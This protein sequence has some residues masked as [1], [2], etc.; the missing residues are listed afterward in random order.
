[1][2]QNKKNA[3]ASWGT[4]PLTSFYQSNRQEQDS[5]AD[6]EQLPHKDDIQ[7]DHDDDV[8]VDTDILILYCYQKN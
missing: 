3:A 5:G 1:M 6:T 2:L 7:E 4:A 8:I